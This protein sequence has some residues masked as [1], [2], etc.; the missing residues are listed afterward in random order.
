MKG[1]FILKEQPREGVGWIEWSR[2]RLGT[3]KGK[4]QAL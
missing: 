4:L 3:L 2:G 1:T